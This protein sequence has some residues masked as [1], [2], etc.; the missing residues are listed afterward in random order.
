MIGKL[1]KGASFGG[2]IRYVTGKD[3]AKILASDGVLLGTNAEIVQSF[4]LQRQLNPRIKKPVGHIALSFKP[5]DKPRLTDE[6]MA[7]IALEYMQ[8]MDITDIQF[9]IVRHHNTDNPHCHIVYN[10]INNEG[11]LISDRND[12]RRNEQVTKALKT[13]YGL[14]YGTDKSKTN[15]RK[16]RNAERAK[17]E[18]HNAVKDALK[19]V[20]NWQK[21]K[22]ELAKRGV[23]L[24]FVYKDKERTKVQGIRFSKDGYSFKGTQISRGYSFGKLNARFEGTENHVSARAISTQQYEQGSFKDE[25]L[26]FMSES[27]QDPWDSISSI[28]LFAP[29]NA[30]TYE[31]FPEDES[32][33]KKKRKRRKGFSL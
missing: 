11:K 23:H 12:Y 1:K 32:A 28:G 33:K 14:T 17:Y 29:S 13:K 16:L 15:T 24:E 20:E 19:V 30:Q 4:E 31:P 27:S 26:P 3:E 25:L 9:I 21:F 7:K 5:E 10:R 2:C 18:I 6:F 8:M 22:N